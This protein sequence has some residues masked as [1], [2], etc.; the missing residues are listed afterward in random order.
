MMSVVSAMEIILH[1]LIVL[2]YQMVIHG[3]VIA[4]VLHLITLVMI[5]MIV[6]VILMVLHGQVIAVVF[7]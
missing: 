3:Q 5:V 2:A 7:H 6:L 1:A 4:V